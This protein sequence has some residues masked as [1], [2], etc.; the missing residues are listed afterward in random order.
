MRLELGDECSELG[1]FLE[2]FQVGIFGHPLVIGVTKRDGPFEDAKGV[3]L[4]FEQGET[5]REVVVRSGVGWLE[6]DEFTIHFESVGDTPGLGV[7]ATENLNHIGVARIATEDGFIESNFEGGIFFA[8]HV[9]KLQGSA[10]LAN[11]GVAKGV[12]VGAD[13]KAL[14]DRRE[15]KLGGN[16]VAIPL[17]ERGA[18]LE[19]LIAIKADH[20]GDLGVVVGVGVVILQIFSDIDLTQQGALGHDRQGAV[21]R[22]AG[23]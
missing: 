23:H 2:R 21:N 7:E 19:Y 20:L 22:G 5:A 18:D 16:G 13:L 9:V 17:H 1:G 3:G 14:G 6:F 8:G 4:A 12:A 11:A 10:V 15:A